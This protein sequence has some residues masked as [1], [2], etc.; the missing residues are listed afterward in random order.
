M[1]GGYEPTP[2]SRALNPVCC[3]A[4][5]PSGVATTVLEATRNRAVRCLHPYSV[6]VERVNVES[7]RAYVRF[8]VAVLWTCRRIGPMIGSSC[9]EGWLE[10]FTGAFPRWAGYTRTANL[11]NAGL[12]WCVSRVHSKD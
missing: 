2:Q 11:G 4:M 10:R 1:I 3:I 5:L 9:R 12:L 6:G 8:G 7:S